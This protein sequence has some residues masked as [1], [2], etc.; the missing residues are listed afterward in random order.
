MID[1]SHRF[2]DW[3]A[4]P[5][6]EAQLNYAAGDVT[7]LR[8]VYEKLVRKL[9]QDKRLSWVAAEMAELEDPATFRPDPE[10]QWERLK[11]RTRQ[12]PYAGCAACSC[13]PA[14]A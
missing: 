5:L 11:A 8:L 10:K 13:R 3:S 9:E 4:R 14:R 6:S 7:W 1:K 2:T 12:P